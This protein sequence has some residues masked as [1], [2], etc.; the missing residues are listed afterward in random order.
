MGKMALCAGVRSNLLVSLRIRLRINHS[1]GRVAILCIRRGSSASSVSLPF[2]LLAAERIPPRSA[3]FA[4]MDY[5]IPA[6]AY[7]KKVI[8]EGCN[9]L[10]PNYVGR[11]GQKPVY[12]A[13]GPLEQM[14]DILVRTKRGVR[15]V[16]TEEWGKLKGCPPS[17][18]TTAKYRRRIIQDPS[19]QFW[20]VMVD[21]FVPTLIDPKSKIGN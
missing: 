19:L 7:I 2:S 15:E 14:D 8:N 1:G 3:S 10:L 6:R 11:I 4:L 17:W 13:N 21:A 20:S 5:K 12:E 18:G 9:T 16:T